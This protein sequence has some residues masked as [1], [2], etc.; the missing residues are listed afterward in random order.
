MKVLRVKTRLKPVGTNQEII[1]SND[2]VVGDDERVKNV[3]ERLY[4]PENFR[5]ITFDFHEL[6]AYMGQQVFDLGRI[7]WGN[8][9]QQKAILINMIQDW[10]E[11]DDSDQQKDASRVEGLLELIDHIQDQA[12]DVLGFSQ[13]EVFPNL[14]KEA[15]DFGEMMTPEDFNYW[16]CMN[17]PIEDGDTFYAK[18][19]PI[20]KQALD[21]FDEHGSL[22]E[23]CDKVIK[24]LNEV[25][26]TAEYGLDGQS[27]FNFW[28]ISESEKD[29]AIN[30]EDIDK[31]VNALN[32]KPLNE[33]QYKYIFDFYDSI[34]EQDPTGGWD[35]WV[36]QMLVD[37]EAEK[38]KESN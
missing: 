11:A 12:V 20:V 30:R 26:Y 10:G 27:I 29:C 15:E 14:E 13:E 22:Y 25:G 7:D 32:Y 23:E 8:L 31:V 3:L 33:A 9:S 16:V 19:P 34:A 6:C 5:I 4:T 24:R 21:S 17:N 1:V 36:E 38:I 18:A 37:I 2:I 35:V 28:A